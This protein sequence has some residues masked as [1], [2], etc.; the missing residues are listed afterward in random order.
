MHAFSVGY[1]GRPPCDERDQARALAERLGMMFHEVEIPV[2]SFVEFFP[3]LVH[4]LDEPIADPAAFGHYAV[5][6]AAADFGIKVLLTGIGGDELFWGYPWVSHNVLV[7][8]KRLALRGMT[9]LMKW[10]LASGL[11]HFLPGV[12]GK[13]IWREAGSCRTPAAQPI[14]LDNTPDFTAAFA[15]KKK[16]YGEAMHALPP[17]TPFIPTDIV[18]HDAG[19]VPLQMLRLLFDTWLISNCLDLG[20]RVSMSVG[21]ESRA[22]FLDFKLIELVMGLRKNRPDHT[23][24][25]KAWLKGALHGILPQE[26]LHRPKRGFQP[27]VKEWLS[28]V[29]KEYGHMLLEGELVQSGIITQRSAEQILKEWRVED[30]ANLF[31]AYKVILAESWTR[32]IRK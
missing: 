1:P 20:D 15:I 25:Q 11:F 7:N 3:K 22:P 19:E 29:V 26:V 30:W 2:D 28:G 24:G 8:T 31:F 21:V 17:E 5:P 27:P 23:L 12:E 18:L 9:R 16:W 32:T 13:K 10:A 4:I 14:F 6:R